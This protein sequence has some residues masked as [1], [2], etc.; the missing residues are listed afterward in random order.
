MSI[1]QWSP[2][3]ANLKRNPLPRSLLSY[4]YFLYFLHLL[5]E[6]HIYN[7]DSQDYPYQLQFTSHYPI[8]F[9]KLYLADLVTSE[10]C[11]LM[12]PTCLKPVGYLT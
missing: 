6:F 1:V 12:D 8:S 5:I 4:L 10:A 7:L 2:K 9:I 3:V 11:Y